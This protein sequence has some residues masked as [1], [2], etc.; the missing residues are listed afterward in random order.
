MAIVACANTILEVHGNEESIV[1][2]GSSLQISK[3][4]DSHTVSVAI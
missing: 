3:K 1:A 2:S 4:L